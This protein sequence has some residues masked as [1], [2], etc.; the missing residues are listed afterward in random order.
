MGIIYMEEGELEKSLKCHLKG[1]KL[2]EMSTTQDTRPMAFTYENLG[3]CYLAM[4]DLE[5]AAHYLEL[6]EKIWQDVG[7]VNSDR[8]AESV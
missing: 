3:L 1:V 5:H 6:A 7:E 4:N 2:R 8:Y